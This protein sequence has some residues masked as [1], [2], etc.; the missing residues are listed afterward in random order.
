MREDLVDEGGLCGGVA[1]GAVD[2]A[3]GE[4]GAQYGGG[5][6]CGAGGGIKEAEGD[7]DAEG[8][9]AG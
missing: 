2:A 4:D 3:R 7:A 8:L 6:G 1:D 9:G 5:L